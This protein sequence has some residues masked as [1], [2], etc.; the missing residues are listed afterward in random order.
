MNTIQ[1]LL[2]LSVLL[3]GILAYFL[4]KSFIL[5]DSLDDYIEYLETRIAD[6]FVKCQQVLA[7]MRTLDDRQMFEKDDE[8][9]ALFTQLTIVI[10]ELRTLL[11]GEEEE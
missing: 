4:R 8:V 11:Y 10:G 3:N 2:G 5:Q 6:F 9:G 7:D 1:I